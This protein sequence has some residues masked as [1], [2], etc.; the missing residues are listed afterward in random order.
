MYLSTLESES[1]FM[2]FFHRCRTFWQQ[3][4]GFGIIEAAITLP[5]FLM[6]TFGV[7]EF[8]NIYLQRY[9]VRDVSDAVKDYLQAKPGATTTE[10][11][12]FL[13]GLGV[14]LKGTG[15]T[16]ENHIITKIR[17]AAN[18]TIYTTAQFDALCASS[19]AAAFP[20]PNP[21][22]S[23]TDPANDNSQYFIHICYRYTYTAITPLPGLTAGVIPTTKVLNGKAL[24]LINATTGGGIPA[25]TLMGY[26]VNAWGGWGAGNLGLAWPAKVVVNSSGPPESTTRCSCENGWRPITTG[27]CIQGGCST[28]AIE[29]G[30]PTGELYF[31]ACIKS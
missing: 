5:L 23:D 27:T 6:I 17:I 9:A 2:R 7:I 13:N 15:G 4:G 16:E 22:A 12:T 8:G 29:N 26:C 24:A 11:T 31:Y 3:K 20:I 21:W 28:V 25:G 30:S 18:K 1:I 10:M 19:A 14:E